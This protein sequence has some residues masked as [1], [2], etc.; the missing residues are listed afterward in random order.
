[1]PSGPGQSIG[2]VAPYVNNP[3]AGASHKAMRLAFTMTGNVWR[4]A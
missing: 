3:T 1:M 4:P 2:S